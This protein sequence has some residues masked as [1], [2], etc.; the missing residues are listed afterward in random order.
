MST[1]I[2]EM[3]FEIAPKYSTAP[4]L[5]QLEWTH[6]ATDYYSPLPPLFVIAY[7]S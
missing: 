1:G 3:E 5:Y 4:G 7:N 2:N 6:D